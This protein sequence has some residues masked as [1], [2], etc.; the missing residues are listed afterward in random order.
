MSKA[1]TISSKPWPQSLLELLERQQGMVDQLVELAQSQA[2]L[3]AGS[4]TDRLLEILTRRQSIIDEFTASQSHLTELTRGLDHNLDTVATLDR[5]RIKSFISEI[6]QRLA[7]IL[8]RD[9][10]D[11]ASLRTQSSQIKQELNSLGTARQA[12]HAYQGTSA[13]NRFADRHG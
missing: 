1:P 3:I 7:L 4:H 8:D 12:R 9:E 2:S 6:G 5:D 11:Q 10:Q 13:T